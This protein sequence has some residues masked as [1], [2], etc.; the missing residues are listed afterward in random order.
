[1]QCPE[2]G[3][4]FGGQYG[5][6]AVEIGRLDGKI[7]QDR[8]D[9]AEAGS[10]VIAMAGQHPDLAALDPGGDAVSVDLHF[11]EPGVALGRPLDQGGE[12]ERD[13][14]GEGVGRTAGH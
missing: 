3:D 11:M 13:E 14:V 12:L 8:G 7:G 5:D 6:L 10:P 4:A 2:V 9:G 1:L